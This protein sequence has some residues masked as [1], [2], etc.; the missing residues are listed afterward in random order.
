VTLVLDVDPVVGLARAGGGGD[1]I[2]AEG[3]E[4]QERVAAGFAALARRYPERVRLVDGFRD[5]ELVAA[6][7]EAAALEAVADAGL[8]LGG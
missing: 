8:R 3:L 2:E 7:V 4:F 1:R 6:E 5:V